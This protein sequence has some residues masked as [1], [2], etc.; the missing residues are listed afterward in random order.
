MKRTSLLLAL[1]S[2]TVTTLAIDSPEDPCTDAQLRIVD[3]FDLFSPAQLA[4]TLTEKERAA[5][6]SVGYMNQLCFERMLTQRDCETSLR[7]SY[8][9]G[10]SEAKAYALLGLSFIKSPLYVTLKAD[11][12]RY[13]NSTVV[14]CR[15]SGLKKEE[16]PAGIVGAIDSGKL[17]AKI[18]PRKK[19]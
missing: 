14:A 3:S 13:Q 6:E 19:Y 7:R 12:L 18:T 17:N 8:F 9:N 1:V 10:T 11:F 16:T 15:V 2:F 5:G 4:G